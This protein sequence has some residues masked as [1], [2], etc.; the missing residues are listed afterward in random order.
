MPTR[1]PVALAP[2]VTAV[3]FS[4]IVAASAFAQPATTPAPPE[5]A[6]TAGGAPTVV[7]TVIVKNPKNAAVMPY[8]VAYERLK[9]MQ[10]SKLDRVR[11]QIRITPKDAT[12]K[13]GD[14][15]A[16]IVNDTA[17]V[18]LPIAQDGSIEVPL[19]PDLYKT[20][21][22]IRTNQPKGSLTAGVTIGV[23]WPGGSEIAYADVEE[24][25]RQIQ[26][27]GKDVMGWFAYMLFFP[28]LANFE[29]PVQFPVPRGQTMK[30]MKDGRVV[31]TYTADDKG[32]LKFR[33][34]REWET[35]QPVL[36]FSEVLPKG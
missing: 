13:L 19:R 28:S 30:V 26:H 27:A 8:D 6:S 21:A 33:L 10:D 12:V 2:R 29:V 11:L 23:G 18:P 31:E 14:V 32:L 7:E 36:V 20:D 15:R 9:R 34:K 35:L 3:L 24:T 1:L 17:S 4:L 25:V 5:A 22:E 16:A